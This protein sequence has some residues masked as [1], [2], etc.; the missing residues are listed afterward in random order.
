[1][2]CTV[3]LLAQVDRGTITGTVTDT[4]GAVVP[5][6][7][8]TVTNPATGATVATHSTDSGTYTVVDLPV[9]VYT[10][11]VEKEGFKL[12]VRTGVILNAASEVRVDFSLQIGSTRQ[13]VEVKGGV[14]P[15][16]TETAKESA[17]ISNVMVQDLPIVVGAALRSPLDLAS[18]TPEAKNYNTSVA[19]GTVQPGTNTSDSFSIGGGQ[20]RA[21]GITLDGISLMAGNST[22]NS[23]L[24]YNTPPLDAITEFTVETNGYKAEFGHAQGGVMTFSS[25]TG[26]NGLHGSAFEFLRNT[27]LDANTFFGNEKGLPRSIY[28]Q[29]DFGVNA[30]GPVIIPHII[31]GKNKTFFYAAYEGFRNRVGANGT[32]F[33]LPTA[34]MLQGDFS[35]WVNSA[36]AMIPIYDPN[37]TALNPT[38]GLYT[39]CQFGTC[40]GQTGGLNVI[41]STEFDPLASKLVGVFAGGP[42][43]QLL[44]N[45]T[46]APGTVGAVQSN[47]FVTKGTVVTPWNKFSINGDHIINDKN[48]ISG[49]YGRTRETNT[50][51]PDGAPVL[52]GYY[53]SYQPQFNRSDVFRASWTHTFSPTVLNYAYIGANVWKQFAE[54]YQEIQGNW[55]SKFCYPNVPNCNLNLPNLG[56]GGDGYSAW[57]SGSDSGSNQ[58]V[59]SYNDNLT[60]I[61]GRHTFK[62]GGTYQRNSYDG[63]G[64]SGAAGTIDF[65]TG[66]TSVPGQTN[67]KTGGGNS[68]ASFLL[69]QADSGRIDTHRLIDQVYRYIAVFVQDDWHVSS[70]LTI[71][72][73]LR[74]ETALPDVNPFN[75]LTNFNPTKPNP[76][77]NN[78]PGALDFAGVG[79]GRIGRSD[80]GGYNFLGFGPRLGIA[81]RLDSKTVIRTAYSRSFGFDVT[82][83]GSAHYSGFFQIYLPVN[84][85]SGVEPTWIFKNGFPPYPLPP[86]LDPGFANGNAV[87]W[88][89]GRDGTLLPTLDSWTFSIQRQLTPTT[90]V[91]IAYSA[92]K[93]THLLSGEDNYDQ[94]PFSDFTEYGGTLLNSSATSPAAIAAGITLP[95]PTFTGSVSQALR[96]FPQFTAIDTESGGGDHSGSSEYEALILQLQ[97]RLGSGLTVQTS[98][99]YSKLEDTS[100]GA[101]QQVYA[102]NTAQR[103]LDKSIS[104][105]DLTHNFKLAWVYELPFGKNRRY[106]TS[107][108]ASALLGDW[109]VSAIQNYSSGFPIALATTV[110]FPIFAGS[111]RPT[112][113]SNS[114]WG[115]SATSNF[116][117]SVDTFFKP[118]S[119]FG[120]QSTT[121][122][123]NAPR[124][125]GACRQ[126]PIY[127]ENLSLNRKIRLTE[128]LNLDFRMEG[129]NIFNRVRFGTG[130]TTLQSA[131]FGKLTSN[132]DIFNAPRQVQFAM[133]LNW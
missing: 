123:G 115:C 45:T 95:Y 49:Y 50:G 36:G 79:P 34:Q 109:R 28:K 65:A 104:G 85:T 122:F 114:G 69:G 27:D 70:R 117:P 96:P 25:K 58:P 100:E 33:T 11:Q 108:V 102:M 99:V 110:S 57:G 112:V 89:Q 26:T 131:T 62:F 83:Q 14:T 61:H 103:Y 113:P 78:I 71:N 12:S 59:Y 16:N 18:L 101:A 4:T 42:T 54:P 67:Y 72:A 19:N 88:F 76:D 30:G 105:D 74:W 51:G 38:T 10:V 43:G 81:Y 44:P 39:R 118:E 91:E 40:P 41:P 125:N 63:L 93:G 86:I 75:E 32:A 8:I 53:S 111:N 23:W 73:G 55:Q 116:D 68:F 120:P 15:L 5:G 9:G 21:F 6:A 98:Y 56:F 80:F 133:R 119:F 66:E 46:A 31:N 22:P 92:D 52:P 29:N 121:T 127:N 129:Y 107:G 97:K 60:W 13:V 35:G 82:A 24:T 20:P 17:T 64:D 84:T 77:A 48:S 1:L 132:N 90:M 7:S 2:F 126:F 130:S 124:Y 37:S 47:Y 87:Q 94:T 128:K 106:L 3:P